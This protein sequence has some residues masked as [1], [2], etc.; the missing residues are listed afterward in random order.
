MSPFA[1][2]YYRSWR[3]VQSADELDRFLKQHTGLNAMQLLEVLLVDQAIQWQ[4]APGPS[5]EQ[6]L[7]RFPIVSDQRQAVL[8]LVYGEMRAVCTLGQQV[9][10]D[11]YIAR[12]PDLAEPLRRQMEVSKWL[13]DEG[14]G[15]KPVDRPTSS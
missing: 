13:A 5:V 11:A 3:T 14:G 7:Q 15:A 12:F 2:C 4:A 8:E 10:V 9:D 6:Y 1:E